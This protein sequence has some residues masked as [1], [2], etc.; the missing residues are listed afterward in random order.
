MAELK[1]ISA[2]NDSKFIDIQPFGQEYRDSISQFQDFLTRNIQQMTGN[3]R[4]P[5]HGLRY[6]YERGILTG[7][8]SDED[9]ITINGNCLFDSL[10][11]VLG[12][13]K[14]DETKEQYYERIADFRREL[15]IHSLSSGHRIGY[16]NLNQQ[17]TKERGAPVY[18]EHVVNNTFIDTTKYVP[19]GVIKSF[20]DLKKRNV[21]LFEIHTNGILNVHI[22]INRN[23]PLDHVEFL[24]LHASHFTTFKK[25]PH[26][27]QKFLQ[28]LKEVETDVRDVMLRQLYTLEV[29]P[30]MDDRIYH[31]VIAY[32][33]D[34]LNHI[35]SL[36]GVNGLPYLSGPD[37]PE[38]LHS[39]K[40]GSYLGN[41]KNM[42]PG[43]LENFR[44][45]GIDPGIKSNTNSGPYLSKNEYNK[46]PTKEKSEYTQHQFDKDRPFFREF[47][48][49]F[50]A[51]SGFG[52]IPSNYQPGPP[53]NVI[54]LMQKMRKNLN[55]SG[56]E[57]HPKSKS[58]KS[59]SPK[60]KSPKS[61]S[62]KSPSPKSPSPKSPKSPKRGPKPGPKRG[63]KPGPKP[64]PRARKF[65]SNEILAKQLGEMYEQEAR[66]E[67]LARKIQN[68]LN[69][70]RTQR[71]RGSIPS[72]NSSNRKSSVKSSNSPKR[73]GPGP[74]RPPPPK[75]RGRSVKKLEK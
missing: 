34:E 51:H 17:A 13:G 11:Y 12:E 46:L 4:Q 30:D 65:K 23:I 47:D 45:A 62:P 27:E 38:N 22:Y 53:V 49:K 5:F 25:G 72:G 67:S 57:N 70:N 6:N 42:S 32:N 39:P 55:L 35:F 50:A 63:P 26:V 18:R 20:C 24:M 71:N 59:K 3:F 44:K 14:K 29:I 60:S 37:L 1:S 69:Q 21:I 28:E 48:S 33:Y 8:R 74:S 10:L 19:A 41:A 16:E 56:K 31:Q 7:F 40:I 66:N 64:I 58:P 52:S 75:P 54:A 61:K 43:M 15:I 73:S 68:G 36:F 9:E 2:L